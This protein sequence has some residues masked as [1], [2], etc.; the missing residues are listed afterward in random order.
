MRILF[1]PVF[2]LFAAIVFSA[3]FSSAALAA[4]Q[5]TVKPS[6]MTLKVT[7]DDAKVF[8]DFVYLTRTGDFVKPAS[9]QIGWSLGD[10][11]KSSKYEVAVMQGKDKGQVEIVTEKGAL[12]NYRVSVRDAKNNE[13]GAVGLQVQNKGQTEYVAISHP[14]YTEPIIIYGNEAKPK[15]YDPQ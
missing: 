14:D 9:I 2:L 12:I 1:R 4:E 7:V 13:I 10:V 8:W 11:S 15:E 3:V 5:A 6:K